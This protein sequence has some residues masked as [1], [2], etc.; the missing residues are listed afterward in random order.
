MP[1]PITKESVALCIAQAG[2]RGI[3]E[4]KDGM[5]FNKKKDGSRRY[6][7]VNDMAEATLDSVKE[8]PA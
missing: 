8:S 1:D 3:A 4:S 2:L 6:Y 5:L 7:S